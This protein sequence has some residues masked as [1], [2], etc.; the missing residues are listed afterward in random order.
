[1]SFRRSLSGSAVTVD[2]RAAPYP[3]SSA[4]QLEAG[5]HRIDSTQLTTRTRR[6]RLYWIGP[7]AA[8]SDSSCHSS[9]RGDLSW[10]DRAPF[11][12]MPRR[13]PRHGVAMKRGKASCSSVAAK[14]GSDD[15]ELSVRRSTDRSGGVWVRWCIATARAAMTSAPP[16]AQRQRAPQV[17]A[18]G[19]PA[20]ISSA[21]S[22]RLRAGISLCFHAVRRSTAA[23]SEP[24]CSPS[25]RHSEHDGAAAAGALLGEASQ[26]GP[27]RRLATAVRA[28]DGGAREKCCCSVSASA[29]D[30]LAASEGRDADVGL[31]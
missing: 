31:A 21:S 6:R 13:I 7:T 12:E 5:E 23:G 2:G 26:P 11:R 3:P 27:N 25:P 4:I 17:L 18:L 15:G 22:S 28:R 16:S 10:A 20:R 1:M 30:D 9:S 19:S 29:S 14:R 8:A 24:T